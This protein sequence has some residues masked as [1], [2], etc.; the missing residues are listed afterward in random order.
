[1]LAKL[2]PGPTWA[3][4]PSMVRRHCLSKR[5]L[6]SSVSGKLTNNVNVTSKPEHGENVT[7][8]ATAD[9][10][11][12]LSGITVEKTAIPDDGY[13]GTVVTFPIKITNNQTVKLAHVKAVDILPLGMVYETNGTI[14]SP[15]SV[16]LIGG[17]YVVTWNDLGPLN[18]SE[19][20]DLVLKSQII[21]NVMGV[22]TN[23]INTTGVPEFGNEVRARDTADVFVESV[24]LNITKE[25]SQTDG[26]PGTIINYTIT[27][28]N[29][30]PVEFCQVSSWDILPEGLSYIGDDHGGNLTEPN[31]VVWDNLGCL[32]PGE[33]IVIELEASITGTVMGNL[34]NV[35][36]VQGRRQSDGAL[37][38]VKSHVKV[39][40]RGE[41]FNITKTSDK[42]TYRP[43]EEMTYTITV[44]N[45]LPVSLVDVIVKDVFQNPGVVVLSSY[46]ELN[47]DGQWYFPEIGPDEQV[48]DDAYSSVSGV[49]YNLQSAA[50]RI[51]KRFR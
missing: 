4:L 18:S 51:G 3:L 15:S 39:E 5:K 16:V 33:T 23:E 22:V 47:G 11:S 32:L 26:L 14:P 6:T 19:S 27:I 50:K 2:S 24:G 17:R 8:N 29:T 36:S 13:S 21:G 43:G 42:S 10:D 45:P 34:D 28:N 31:K 46:P 41:G 20:H 37:M 49:K 30:G 38:V 35:V 12:Q 7:S 40:A 48:R 25:A 44:R 1:M 9:V